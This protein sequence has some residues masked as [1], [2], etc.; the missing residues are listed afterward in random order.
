MRLYIKILFCFLL[1]LLVSRNASATHNRAGEIT[2]VQIGPL[3]IEATITTY[4]KASSTSADRDS[5]EL[6]WGD[7]TSTLIPRSNGN[8][9]GEL[10]PGE[11]IKI[12]KY[13]ATHTYPGR[14]TYKLSF[15]DPN[16]VNNI[17]NVNFPNSVDVRFYVETSFTFTNTQFQGYNNSVVLLQPPIDY[18]CVNERFVHNPNAYDPDGD[19]L[20]FELVIPLESEGVEVPKYEFPNEASQPGPD[21]IISLDPVSGDFVWDSPKSPGEYNIAIRINEYRNGILLNSV[22]RDMQIFVDIC[23]SSPPKIDVIKEICVIAG[24]RIDIPVTVSDADETDLVRLSATGGPFLHPISP[25]IKIEQEIFSLQPQTTRFIWDTKCEH[26]S[27]NYYQVVFRAQDNSRTSTGIAVLKTLRIKVIAPSPEGLTG[28]AINETIQ[29]KWNYDYPCRETVDDYFIGFSVWRKVNPNPFIPDSCETGLENRGYEIVEFLTLENDGIHFLHLDDV[30]LEKGKIYCY[31]V[32]AHFAQ[33]TPSGNPFNIVASKA[34]SE[35][36]LQLS[37]DIPLITKVSVMNTSMSSGINEIEWIKPI[38]ED[39]DTIE[40]P[41]PYRYQLSRSVDGV[42]FDEIPGASFSAEY[43]NSPVIDRFTDINLNTDQLQYYYKVDFYSNNTFY[44][45]SLPASSVF[46]EIISSD[47][48]NR[49]M[50]SEDVPWENFEYSIYKQDGGSYFYLDF[51]RENGFIDYEVENDRDYCYYIEAIGTYGLS[52]TPSPLINL[53]QEVC[54]TPVDTVG[55][56]APELSIDNPCDELSEGTQILDLVNTLNWSSVKF[57]CTNSGDLESYNI[58]YSNNI[59]NELEWIGNVNDNAINIF[60]HVPEEG[61]NGCYAVASVDSL[62]NEGPF[63]N[64]VCV[65]NCPIYRLPNTFTPNND[66]ANDFFIPIENKFVH[67]IEFKVFNRWGNLVFETSESEINWNG[68]DL[69]GNDVDEGSY[70]Y[71]C[72][73]YSISNDGQV[74]ETDILNGH[75]QIFR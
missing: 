60:E 43:F 18:A 37:Q 22:I 31:R 54:G 11:D 49:L 47:N 10:I 19:S 38:A 74:N 5:L 13:I 15:S 53:S 44:G 30:D 50:W 63:S 6:F 23:T 17:Q 2:Y 55:P 69:S 66:N 58:Y 3:T 72:R 75:I 8:G 73:I 41:G 14:A 35:I 29:L 1:I 39:L 7:G 9:E 62:G 68:K 21:N 16:R 42:V 32:L 36:C 24:T 4:T 26:V 57:N 48:Q 12:N 34:S 67:S 59:N 33:K 71:I 27:D 64:T 65:D 70:Y 61:I 51:S 40:N 20:S 45:S 46:L 56:C 25:A 52:N 28:E